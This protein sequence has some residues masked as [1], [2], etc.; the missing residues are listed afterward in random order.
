MALNRYEQAIVRNADFFVSMQDD[1]GGLWTHQDE[2][3]QRF[4][5]KYG[6]INFYGAVALWFFNAVYERGAEPVA[7]A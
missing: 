5:E 4:G 2:S 6:N 7:P 3:G 1:D